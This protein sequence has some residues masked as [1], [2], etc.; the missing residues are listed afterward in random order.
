MQWNISYH[1]VIPV[2][3]YVDA[4][5]VVIDYDYFSPNLRTKVV[6]LFGATNLGSP[7]FLF[8]TSRP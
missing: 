1:G 5:N 2:T 6:N 3:V 7:K 8:R 4:C